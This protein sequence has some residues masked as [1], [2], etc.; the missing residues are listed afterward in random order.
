MTALWAV[1]SLFV[2]LASFFAY[3][4]LAGQEL[5]VAIAFTALSL[6][7]L[8]APFSFPPL[9]VALTSSLPYSIRG[10]LNQIPGFGIRILQLQVSIQRLETFFKED[11]IAFHATPDARKSSTRLALNE[12]T[13]RYAGSEGGEPVLS[14]VDV[15]FPQG[16]LTVISGPTGSGKSSSKS[17]SLSCLMLVEAALTPSFLPVLLALL[18][19]LEVVSGSVELPST[20][21]YAAQHPWLESLSLRD[22]MCVSLSSLLPSDPTDFSS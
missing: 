20:V 15:V 7:S 4:K 12:A 18:G 2:P 16:R 3:T 6:F 19:E 1:I 8:S 10:P 9:S 5:T 17:P 22:N 13:L 21:S 14:D 11:E